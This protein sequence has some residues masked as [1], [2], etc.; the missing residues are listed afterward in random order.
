MQNLTVFQVNT[1]D[2]LIFTPVI[3][4]I[5]KLYGYDRKKVM[6]FGVYL[7]S[8]CISH[9]IHVVIND[10]HQ[11]DCKPLIKPVMSEIS[12]SLFSC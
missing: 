8:F 2:F 6:W 1:E 5:P 12:D 9:I 7:I 4:Y 10:R 3:K 11:V